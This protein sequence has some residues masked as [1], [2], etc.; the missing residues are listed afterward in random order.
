[1]GRSVHCK[2]MIRIAV[3]RLLEHDQQGKYG[4]YRDHQQLI[5]V[6]VGDDLRLLR[7]HGVERSTS[8]GIE[9]VPEAHDH[10]ALERTIYGGNV[11]H[12]V[13]MIDLRVARQQSIHYRN[14]NT[15]ANV[16]RETV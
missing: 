12:D 8:G 5:I 9:R 16:P 6:D 10:R 1:M 2:R 14:A 7:D 11:L 4:K 13:G 15:G 3:R